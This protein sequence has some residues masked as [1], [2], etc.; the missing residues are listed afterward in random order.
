MFYV[1]MHCIR[2]ALGK[3]QPQKQYWLLFIAC[4]LSN[5][6]S[7]LHTV[8]YSIF[9]TNQ[10]GL[11]QMSEL[12]WPNPSVE[13]LLSFFQLNVCSEQVFIFQIFNCFT[14]LYCHTT[15]QCVSAIPQCKSIIVIHISPPSKA[16][17]PHSHPTPLGISNKTLKEGLFLSQRYFPDLHKLWLLRPFEKF[18]YQLQPYRNE[19]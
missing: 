8:S 1:L 17:L 14:V 2:S 6:V 11:T 19:L 12:A 4:L 10:W 9:I 18:D 15:M 3:Q 16:S 13:F 5:V 7:V